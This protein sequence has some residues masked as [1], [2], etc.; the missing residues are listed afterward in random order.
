MRMQR[1]L[2]RIAGVAECLTGVAL[3]TLPALTISLLL[4]VEPAEDALMIGRIAGAAL[5]ALGV[6]CWGAC[7][8]VGGAA[9]NGM[10]N[11]M[12]FYNTVT[13]ALLVAYVVTGKAG[14]TVGLIVGSLHLLIAAAFALCRW[15]ALAGAVRI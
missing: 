7:P 3:M 15:R 12:T 2:L 9:L 8:Q 10:L 1:T 5:F 11:A 6:A 4:G 14:G 13:G